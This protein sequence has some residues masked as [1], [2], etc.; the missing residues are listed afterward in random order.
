MPLLVFPRGA[1]YALPQLQQAGYDV[2]TLD[3][4]ADRAT[5]RD[6][7]PDAVL[8]GNFDPALLVEGT[9]ASV[10]A[11][12]DSMLDEL[13]SQ[14]LIAN[15]AEGLGGKEQCELVAAFVDAVHAYT[16]KQPAS[17]AAGASPLEASP[18]DGFS[19]GITA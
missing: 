19:W 17:A 10:T 9:P 18:P 12:V 15:L 4:S 13:G 7:Y 11:A 3:D 16:P 8:Q 5:V 6:Q 2:L 14:K 1:A